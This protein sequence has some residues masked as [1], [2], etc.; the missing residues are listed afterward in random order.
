MSIVIYHKGKCAKAVPLLEENF[1]SIL[2][3]I[4]LVNTV[5]SNEIIYK[6]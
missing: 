6:H 3:N 2:Y 4:S 5:T 1:D